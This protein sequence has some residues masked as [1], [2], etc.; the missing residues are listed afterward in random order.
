RGKKSISEDDFA[1]V[2]P[3]KISHASGNPGDA[4]II[5]ASD[6]DTFDPDKPFAK[7][8]RNSPEEPP[9]VL[10]TPKLLNPGEWID[11][12][13][14]FNGDHGN[15]TVNAHFA[16]DTP[17]RPMRRLDMGGPQRQRGQI[18]LITII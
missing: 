16:A 18:I 10:I 13:L 5:D 3:I 4:R 11:V 8:M 15:M 17:V 1:K 9:S 7:F 12:Q 6:P 14:L 2:T